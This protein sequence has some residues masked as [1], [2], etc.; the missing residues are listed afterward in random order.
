MRSIAR[1]GLIF[2]LAAVCVGTAGAQQTYYWNGAAGGANWNL[3]SSWLPNTGWPVAGDT[4][5]FTGT[6]ARTVNL[7][8]N[9]AA[10]TMIITNSAPWT[11]NP[12]A[13]TQT[14]S[15]AFNYNSTATSTFNAALSGAMALN[16]SAGRLLLSN[17]TNTFNGGI[18]IKGGTLVAAAGTANALMGTLGDSNQTI[19]IGDAGVTAD[20]ALELYGRDPALVYRNPITV[21]AGPGKAYL[22]SSVNNG[23]DSGVGILH[24]N[25]IVLN[26]DLTIVN[27][28]QRAGG[29]NDRRIFQIK[30]P[31]SG[32]GALVKDGVGIVQFDGN[33]SYSGTT[34]L[35]NGWLN[36]ASG[37]HTFTGAIRVD[38]G[39]LIVNADAR[40]GN[41]ANTLRLGSPGRFG[42]LAATAD[43]NTSRAVTLDGNG[44]M[45]GSY[46]V[47][48][49]FYG[50]IDGPGRLV[51]QHNA[52]RTVLTNAN[53]YTGGTKVSMGRLFARNNVASL[54][55]GNV[56]VEGPY[57]L[58]TISGAN[59]VNAGAKVLVNSGGT[60][61][62]P[63]D[64]TAV[65]TIDANSSGRLG[66]YATSGASVKALL[67]S[68]VGNGYMSI[69]AA[70]SVDD[71]VWNF[72]FN[73]TSLAIGAENTYRLFAG[74]SG[75]NFDSP[76]ATGVLVDVGATPA[77]VTCEGSG[78]VTSYDA[79]PFTGRLT[80]KAL[81]VYQ[82]TALASGSAM[83]GSGPVSLI[84][85][86]LYYNGGY[87]NDS[88]PIVKGALTFESASTI[89]FNRVGANRIS[90]TAASLIRTNGGCLQLWSSVVTNLISA[91]TNLGVTE[92]FIVTDSPVSSGGMVAPYITLQ[93]SPTEY[94]PDFV[95]YIA[96]NGFTSVVY[97]IAGTPGTVG[98]QANFDAT[99]SSDI[100]KVTNTDVVVSGPKTLQALKT[101]MAVTGAG[102]TLTLTSGGLILTGVNK[103]NSVNLATAGEL[104]VT[105][106]GI[107]TG[108]ATRNTLSGTITAAG[109]T[110]TG[111]GTL[112][113]TNADNT[114]T[115]IGDIAIDQGSI[116]VSNDNQLGAAANRIILNNDGG[117]YTDGLR[118]IGTMA[119]PATR[120]IVLGAN[121][122]VVH[123]P[124]YS[125]T[126]AGKIT[127]AGSLFFWGAGTILT[128]PN[129]DYT[130]GTR[131]KGGVTLN[132]GAQ[133]G[134]GPVYIFNGVTLAD[135]VYRPNRFILGNDAAGSQ[136]G[137][138][139]TAPQ[140]GSL[141]G[142]L[143]SGASAGQQ[144]IFMTA[145]NAMLTV[146]GNDLSTELFA[147]IMD[148]DSANGTYGNSGIVK[149]G[150]GTFTLWG[151][152]NY[153]GPTVVTNGTLVVNNLLHTSSVVKVYSGATLDGIGTVGV[154]SNL[155]GTVKGNLYMQRLIMTPSASL[156]VTLNG[157]NAAS[158]YGQLNVSEAIVLEGTLNVTLGFAPAV[159]QSFT[160]INNTSAAQIS[161]QFAGSGVVVPFGG[162]NY[163]FSI[164]SQGGD[165]NDLVLTRLVTGT[166][167]TI[168]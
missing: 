164:N 157:T 20:S 90:M 165:G 132:N 79:Q 104:V 10:A 109:L 114:A 21:P 83:G 154:V 125:A 135:N 124:S 66:F 167:M 77:N 40:L 162:R 37:T 56:V 24:T 46:A 142:G 93:A 140:V 34:T 99:L 76:N 59:S 126:I 3:N 5:L 45:L 129:N 143:L 116:E 70:N 134:T 148:Y 87:V 98:S 106:G 65:P 16:V 117:N 150:L 13:S 131:I 152:N 133:L 26:D 84:R 74:G 160:L 22:I 88:A 52:N 11:F 94:N 1:L 85:G 115:L 33:N 62:M 123:C 107:G 18:A 23:G 67:A 141:E 36:I 86:A 19:T 128:N 105:V 12:S 57:G 38:G 89:T 63:A 108:N 118:L 7:N 14:V 31:I 103:T 64:I 101:S 156:S 147:A 127:G 43:L 139:T 168:R 75:L 110:K 72:T 71:T 9:Q 68:P 82:G 25:Q 97:S 121:G 53:S 35:K 50:P 138:S 47:N 42:I 91:H 113:L 80:V 122:G 49:S 159:G 137:F 153:H 151:L 4:A 120:T 102:N 69:G 60:F 58:V 51:L 54:G 149:T 6:V 111:R 95:N 32:T 161:G 146:G 44:G 17:N 145:A 81:S 29:Y 30:G 55:T 136:I 2:A 61:T 119:L 112:V 28:T 15:S 96:P 166:I 144:T 78:W 158:Q 48:F 41:S 73:G 155:G 27:Q 92:K 8:G 100:V 130:G 39:M 163:F